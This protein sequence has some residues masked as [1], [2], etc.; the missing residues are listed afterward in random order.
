[1]IL[2]TMLAAFATVLV[3]SSAAFAMPGTP[4]AFYGSATINGQA[5]PDGAAVD[6]RINGAIVASTTVSGGK[7]GYDP[8]F[9]VAD[10]NNTICSPKCPT[11]SL[12][13]NGVDSGKTST[14][15][16]GCVTGLDLS[17]TQATP[18]PVSSS[19]SSSSG[20]GGGG[21]GAPVVTCTINGICDS[22]E[23]HDACPSDCPI[24]TTTTT[25]I[26]SASAAG[27]C[28][29]A[30]TCGDWSSCADG[31]QKRTCTD[32]NNC[33][34]DGSK[35]MESQPCSTD[36]TTPVNPFSGFISGMASAF[37]GSAMLATGVLGLAV[38]AAVLLVLFI[39]LKKR[40]Q[41]P[42]KGKPG[43]GMPKRK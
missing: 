38:L 39:F 43:K 26:A 8:A 24:S 27:T 17:I 13:V 19:G 35:P 15:C 5:A 32:S 16:N 30:W 11:I 7:Y 41:K 37:G 4:N 28:T 25:G 18:A 12:F 33:G 10:P 14:F 36:Y 2:K 42:R 34:T 20:G 6:A 29:E 21:G 22:W 23:T 9:Y 40:K 3:L 31:L 1:M